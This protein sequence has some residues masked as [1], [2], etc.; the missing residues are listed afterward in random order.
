MKLGTVFIKFYE[1]ENHAQVYA[2]FYPKKSQ[3]V[4]KDK[5]KKFTE[6]MRERALESV[7]IWIS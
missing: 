7:H 3:D 4:F 5:D 2:N 6:I 1:L